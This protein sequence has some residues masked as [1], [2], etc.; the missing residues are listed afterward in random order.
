M[1]RIRASFRPLLLVFLAGLFLAACSKKSDSQPDVDLTTALTGTYEV[2]QWVQ[3]DGTPLPTILR[4]TGTSGV[5]VTRVSNNTVEMKLATDMQVTYTINGVSNT[6]VGK[7]SNTT[8]ITV[9]KSAAGA[10]ALV[11]N[12]FSYRD[13]ELYY[14]VCTV[15]LAGTTSNSVEVYALARKK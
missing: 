11:G 14:L 13:G 1:R 12:K 8:P 4:P 3:K 10:I 5:V 7:E 9:T 6:T 2:S 15:P